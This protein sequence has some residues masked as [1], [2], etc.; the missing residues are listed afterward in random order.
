MVL[1]LRADKISID[2]SNLIFCLFKPWEDILRV[3]NNLSKISREQKLL[4]NFDEFFL[5]IS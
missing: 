1:E 3:S 5:M 4:I 2:K